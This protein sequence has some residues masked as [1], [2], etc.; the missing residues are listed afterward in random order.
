MKI[1]FRRCQAVTN[2]DSQHPSSGASNT[3][4]LHQPL[5]L[6]LVLLGRKFND[7]HTATM[8][9]GD[10]FLVFTFPYLFLCSSTFLDSGIDDFNDSLLLGSNVQTDHP[11]PFILTIYDSFMPHGIDQVLIATCATMCESR[12]CT[13]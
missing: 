7:E 8:P 1:R 4:S 10:Y 3:Q 12:P 11:S 2:M 13:F 6:W 9:R 5:G